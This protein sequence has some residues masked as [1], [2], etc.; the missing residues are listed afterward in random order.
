MRSTNAPVKPAL[1]SFRQFGTG[2]TDINSSQNLFGF[3]MAGRLSV[4]RT[5]VF[6]R[7]GS[8]Q[9]IRYEHHEVKNKREI[10]TS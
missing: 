7:F 3:C 4:L 2:A 9:Y 8:L 10:R 1:V 6:I 5:V